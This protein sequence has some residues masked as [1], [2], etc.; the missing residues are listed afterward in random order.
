MPALTEVI[1]TLL[2]QF[3]S[4]L[5]QEAERLVD[6]DAVTGIDLLEEEQTVEIGIRRD[7]TETTI[8]R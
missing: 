1:P 7:A 8:A 5:R 3:D 6:D 4:P 2:L